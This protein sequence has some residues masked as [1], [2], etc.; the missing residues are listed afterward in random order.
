MKKN[1]D[2]DTRQGSLLVYRFNPEL[3]WRFRVYVGHST[4]KFAFTDWIGIDDG[5]LCDSLLDVRERI[6][7]FEAKNQRVVR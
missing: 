1:S 4:D 5:K 7:G 6:S 3:R 2:I